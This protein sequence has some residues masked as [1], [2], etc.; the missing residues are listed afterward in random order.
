MISKRLFSL[1]ML[2]TGVCVTYQVAFQH[3]LL[4]AAKRCLALLTQQL[5]MWSAK[6]R[7][8]LSNSASVWPA[9][10]PYRGCEIMPVLSYGSAVERPT[11]EGSR[12]F[13]P[14]LLCI[15]V[16][17]ALK[18]HVFFSRASLT[19]GI[20]FKIPGTVTRL[21]RGQRRRNLVITSK[22]AELQQEY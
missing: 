11:L 19:R 5:S 14:H 13:K 3:R 20:V 22:D 18:T 8:P 6:E 12:W 9:I 17:P 1:I 15:A 4:A 21:P 2:Y 10:L 7:A 16:V